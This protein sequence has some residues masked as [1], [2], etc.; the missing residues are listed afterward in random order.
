MARKIVNKWIDRALA[1]G[2][3]SGLKDTYHRPKAPV[4]TEAAE[5]WVVHLACSKP[6]ELG[7]AAEVWAQS[8]LI[9]HVRERAV[10][11]GHPALARAAKTTIQWIPAKRAL[12]PE[13]VQYYLERRDS[14][15]GAKMREVL[16][17]YQ[18]VALGNQNRNSTP[19][20]ITVSVDEK[21][22]L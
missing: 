15:F 10:A 1:V 12:H 13:R 6:K 21:P 14:D 22:G 16:M 19:A 18:E 7:Y 9:Q 4:I 2:V 5:A 3:D 20:V 8:V 17:A 11:A